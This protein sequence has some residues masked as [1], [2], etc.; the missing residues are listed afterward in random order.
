MT[1][2]KEME[3]LKSKIRFN[4][5]FINIYD[6]MNFISKSNKYDVRIEEYQ[7]KLIELYKRVQELKR[8]NKWVKN[9]KQ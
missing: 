1:M 4:K 5:T 7:N 3:R 9:M 8:E 6:Y 2:S